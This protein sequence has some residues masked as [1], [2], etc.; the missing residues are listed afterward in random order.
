MVAT[1]TIFRLKKTNRPQISTPKT[2]SVKSHSKYFRISLTNKCNLNCYFCHNEGQ[3]KTGI[4]TNLSCEEIIWVS[5]I[6]KG[7]G[8]T[9]FKLTGGEPT[10]HPEI[11]SIVKGINNLNVDDLSMITNGYKLF[12]IAKELKENGLHRL[13][14]SLYTLNPIKFAVKNKGTETMLKKVVA[15]IDKALK[16]GYNNLKINYVWDGEDNLQD[17]LDICEFAKSRNIT[18]VL[19]P[20]IDNKKSEIIELSSLFYKLSLIGIREEKKVI[21]NE[22]IVKNLIT[23]INGAKVLIRVEELKDKLPYNMCD[24]CTNKTECREGIFPTRLSSSGKL[25]PCLAND[26]Y[27]FDILEDIKNRN[28]NKIVKAINYIRSL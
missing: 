28:S 3:K 18:I 25:L 22:G 6:A 4:S 16:V 27:S 23:L 26:T 15:G 11:L 5:N 1:T 9:K 2:N 19:L 24:N 21:D 10:L 13:N 7:M 8:Y 17:F 20:I 12:D 14:V